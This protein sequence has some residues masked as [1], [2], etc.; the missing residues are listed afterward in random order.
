MD[1]RTVP[2]WTLAD[3]LVKARRSAGLEQEDLAQRMGLNRR[4]IGRY[5]KG[6]APMYATLIEWAEVCQVDA[7]WLLTGVDNRANTGADNHGYAGQLLLE[8]VA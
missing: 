4:T 8:L 1:A 2:T 7:N 5:E 3:R 6:L